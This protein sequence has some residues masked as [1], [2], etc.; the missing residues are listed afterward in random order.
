M[1]WTMVERQVI[2]LVC[3]CMA[4]VGTMFLAAWMDREEPSRVNIG[5]LDRV[6]VGTLVVLEGTLVDCQEAGPRST[7]LDLGDDDG[8]SVDVFCAFPCQGLSPGVRISVTGRVSLYEGDLELVVEDREDLRVLRRPSSPPLDLGDLL[9]EPWAY[10]GMEPRVSVVVLTGP[11]VDQN[12]E[13][14]WCLVGDVGIEGTAALVL[15]GSWYQGD[16]WDEGDELDLRVVVRYDARSG[17]VYL[18]VLD[19]A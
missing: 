18:E 7:L 9:R 15:L 13:D 4:V 2:V 6:E 12:G 5:S 16:P 11:V 1:V 19:V 8:R 14:R 17:F 3:A 10:E